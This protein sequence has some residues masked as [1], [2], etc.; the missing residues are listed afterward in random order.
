MI[1]RTFLVAGC[2][3]LPVTECYKILVE[4]WRLNL[5]GSTCLSMLPG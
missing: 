5:A 3:S 4:P 1:M 2:Y